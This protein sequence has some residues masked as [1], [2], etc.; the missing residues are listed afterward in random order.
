MALPMT[1]S[2]LYIIL[3]VLSAQF[4]SAATG[5]PSVVL[6]LFPEEPPLPLLLIVSFRCFF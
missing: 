3:T 5:R 4:M 1:Y 6:Y 2:L